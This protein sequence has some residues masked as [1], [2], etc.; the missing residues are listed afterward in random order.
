MITVEEHRERILAAVHALP[1][2]V[3]PVQAALGRTLREPVLSAVDL[4]LFDN[5][6]MDGFAVRFE[7]A[8]GATRDHP[9]VL[10]VVADLPAGTSADPALAPGQAARIMT[11]APLPTDADTVVPFEQTAGG[12]ADSLGTIEVVEAPRSRGMH[13][14]GQGDEC[15]AG[16]VILAS[17]ALLG[18][19][20]LA[21]I[22]A[23]GVAQ[24]AV[25][26]APR[27]AVVSTGDELRAPGESLERGQIPESNST[28][29]AALCAEEGAEVV[30]VTHVDDEGDG[31]R[32]ALAEASMRG[33]DVVITSGGVS[34]GA[35]EVVK[36]VAPMEFVT[37]AMQ[38][39]KPQ[40]FGAGDGRL[41][42]GLPGNP[43]SV[44]VSFEV[45]VRPALLKLQGRARL[46]RLIVRLP[47]LEDW[48]TP[49]GRRQYRPVVVEPEGVRPVSP[50]GSHLAA[51]LG[52]ADAYAIV[53][54]ELDSVAAG[55]VVDV[56]LIS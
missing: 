14:R 18:P 40:G 24:V 28:L 53:P 21:G 7:D 4:P 35:Y 22:A 9:A 27:V 51:S 30:L 12:L 44:A 11:G 45:F 41:L 29:L 31:L 47:V 32:A 55:D 8:A 26:R 43:V 50:G 49:A 52:R 33:S 42:F 15:R 25:S 6:A 17:G 20:Q 56:M 34:A 23:A 46:D 54:A 2:T 5:S 16:D 1:T 37:V 19:R 38:P 10:E 3:I 39:G 48:R 36:N 13:V